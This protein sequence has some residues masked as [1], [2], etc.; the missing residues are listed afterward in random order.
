M[1]AAGQGEC[2]TSGIAGVQCEAADGGPRQV[3]LLSQPCME[4]TF[5][6]RR[7]SHIIQW[8]VTRQ[9]EHGTTHMAHP[10]IESTGLF[11]APVGPHGTGND[12]PSV[13]KATHSWVCLGMSRA[14]CCERHAKALQVMRKLFIL[15][16]WDGC[17]RIPQLH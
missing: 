15:L 9:L 13:C 1:P 16:A 3:S 12:A 2:G 7:C 5:V 17:Q 8:T 14:L 6:T 11:K 10:P 4:H